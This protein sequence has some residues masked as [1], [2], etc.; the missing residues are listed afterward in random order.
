MDTT[1]RAFLQGGVS[2]G[3]AG[4]ALGGPAMAQNRV[5]DVAPDPTQALPPT[6]ASTRKGDMLYRT[7]GR[8]GNRC[9]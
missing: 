1:R 8:P 4:L 5:T 9:P 7:L 3:A 2:V 6:P